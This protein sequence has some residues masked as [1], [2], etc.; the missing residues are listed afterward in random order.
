M[1]IIDWRKYY[2]NQEFA[3]ANI[4]IVVFDI[5]IIVVF[6]NVGTLVARQEG[7]QWASATCRGAWLS[8]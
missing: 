3:I 6:K 1:L 8:E 2:E 5:D 7:G 4:L